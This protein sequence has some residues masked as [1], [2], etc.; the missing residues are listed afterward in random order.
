MIQENEIHEK[1]VH[2]ASAGKRMLQGGGLALIF[3]S[4]FL[5]SAGEGDPDWHKL[6]MVRPLVIVPLSGALGGLFYYNMDHLRSRGGLR[7][8]LANL[9]SFIVYI[10]VLWLGTVLGLDGT[11]WD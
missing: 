11:W 1:P 6:W 5:F 2:A 10:I 4:I 7:N 9:L 3:I 8:V